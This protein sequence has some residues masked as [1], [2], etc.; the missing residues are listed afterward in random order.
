M[1]YLNDYVSRI[2]H[3][4]NPQFAASIRETAEEAYKKISNSFDFMGGR[5]TGLLFGN[6]QS[7]KTGHM[8]GIICAAADDIFPLFILLTT[9]NVKVVRTLE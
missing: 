2:T 3:E 9:D 5:K 4:G 8:F 6:I 7:G 1:S